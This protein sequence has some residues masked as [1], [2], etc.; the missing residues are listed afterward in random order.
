MQV[1]VSTSKVTKVNKYV[2][3]FVAVGQVTRIQLMSFLLSAT[4]NIKHLYSSCLTEKFKTSDLRTK[5]EIILK[6]DSQ[7]KLNIFSL[8]F[9]LHWYI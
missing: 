3:L 8:R 7:T 6:N 1:Y 9:V 2:C 5:V 4:L